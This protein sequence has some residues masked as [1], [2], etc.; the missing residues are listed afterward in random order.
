[1]RLALV[2]LFADIP[3]AVDPELATSQTDVNG[4]FSL[5]VPQ[6]NLRNTLYVVV[7]T[8]DAGLT[9]ASVRDPLLDLNVVHVAESYHFTLPAATSVT[10]GTWN[11]AGSGQN[12]PFLL[13]DAAVEGYLIA[14]GVL[15]FTPPWVKVS[16]PARK[17]YFQLFSNPLDIDAH[18]G[19]GEI[20]LSGS[21][22]NS[23]D[24][25]L[26]EYGHFLADLGGFRQ[27]QG[28]NHVVGRRANAS[29]AW[30]EG[31]AT[32]FAVAGQNARGRTDK[33]RMI[34]N[35]PQNFY[36]Y[37]LEN[38]HDPTAIVEAEAGDDNESSVAFI[39]WDH[40]VGSCFSG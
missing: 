37:D 4:D 38:G 17:D 34:S 14:T 40:R 16:Y 2:K 31:W 35:H 28:G 15:R 24:I 32:F 33:R 13:F 27:T 6:A 3:L 11:V 25:V 22:L 18:Y 10:L 23:P 39:L 20:V 12:G 19:N 7:L 29:L 1:V 30:G 21:Y 5:A 9:I 36:D 26:H 8:R